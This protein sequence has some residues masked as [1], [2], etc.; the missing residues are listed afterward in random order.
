MKKYI[1]IQIKTIQII[2]EFNNI[3]KTFWDLD[4]IKLF[5]NKKKYNIYIKYINIIK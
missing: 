5:Y 3:D 2:K 1:L 4:D